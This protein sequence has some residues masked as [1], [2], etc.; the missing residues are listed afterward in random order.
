MV[1]ISNTLNYKLVIAAYYTR[2]DSDSGAFQG[3]QYNTANMFII[4]NKLHKFQVF[5]QHSTATNP[6]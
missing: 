2:F 5:H 1:A 4:N 6:P 3:I